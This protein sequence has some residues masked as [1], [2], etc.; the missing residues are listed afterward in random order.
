[1]LLFEASARFYRKFLLITSLLSGARLKYPSQERYTLHR[2]L[3]SPQ[4]IN[5]LQ[6]VSKRCPEYIFLFMPNT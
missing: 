2:R 4:Q 5:C 1:M 6:K 3:Q